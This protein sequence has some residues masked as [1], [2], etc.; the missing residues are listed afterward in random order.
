V[1]DRLERGIQRDAARYAG[2]DSDDL[3]EELGRTVARHRQYMDRECVNLNAGTNVVNPRAERWLSEGLGNRPSLGYP[4]DKYEMGMRY[5]EKLEVMA[6]AV[7]KQLFRCEHVEIRVG[8]G[9]LANLYAYMACTRPGDRVLAFPE[10]AAGHVTH[11]RGG[12]AG[13]Y[14]LEVHDVPFD[15]ERMTIDL[16]ALEKCARRLR[17]RLVI[18][19]G[20]LC[21]FPFPV[22]EVRAIADSVG[23]YVMY[24]GAHVA[25]LIAAG[26]FQQ[27]LEEGAHLMTCSTYK[28]FGGPPQ[29]LVLTNSADLARRLDSVAFPGLTANFDL[30]KTAALA[31]AALD[32]REFGREYATACIANARAL[33]EA[34]DGHRCPVHG[35]PGRGYTMS[36]HVAVRAAGLG[37]GQRA[38]RRLEGANIL[39]C[40][41]SLPLPAVEGDYNGIRIGAQEITRWGMKP[42]DMRELADLIARVWRRKERPERIR[43]D[44]LAF[45]SRFQEL[46]YVR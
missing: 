6:L 29:G 22:R 12:A 13:L 1:P 27:P 16:D 37:G 31:V 7:L 42:G 2:L 35:V 11:R 23:A 40:G 36:H 43:R 9:S 8:S 5:A 38:S 4:G 30:A 32:L 46:R 34:L 41:I 18:V 45:R 19:G 3:E 28:S 26:E 14:G 10:S 33:A 24:D 44:T 25:G 21:L 17:P 39:T 15:G 20:S